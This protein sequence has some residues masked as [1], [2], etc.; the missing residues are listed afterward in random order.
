VPEAIAAKPLLILASA[1]PRR[2]ELLAQIGVP[3]RVTVA[4]IDERRQSGESVETSV[5]RLAR[6]K[7]A[8]VF[9]RDGRTVGLPVLAADTAVVLG[10]EWFGKPTTEAE[11][12]VMLGALSGRTHR[13]LTAICLHTS[14][15]VFC[16][17]SESSVRFRTLGEAEIRAYWRTGEPRD[18]AGG[19]AIQ[20][21]A[22][23]FI[24][25]L[26]G[27]YSGVMGLPLFETAALLR[28]AGIA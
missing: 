27:S 9:E 17:L 8:V 7:A 1:S 18:K 3:H 22:A 6:E 23:A 14:R 5:Q 28:Q 19:Y 15:D 26:R 2:R 16:A 20:G 12:V 25:E 24:P 13:V 21:R 10:D 4:D 11:A